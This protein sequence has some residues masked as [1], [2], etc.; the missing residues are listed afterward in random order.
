M[1]S[2][3]PFTPQSGEN[4]KMVRPIPRVVNA[5]P[6]LQPLPQSSGLQVGD[7]YYILFRHKWKILLCSLLGIIL[8]IAFYVRN[9]PPYESRAKLFVRYV[10]AE[11]KPLDPTGEAANMKSPDMRGETIMSAERE[12]LTSFDLA[13]Q[14]AETIGPEKLLTET[15]DKDTDLIRA[16][17]KVSEGLTVDAPRM[18]SV[19]NV[20]FRHT[21]PALVQPVLAEIIS[22]YLKTH[23]DIHRAVGI[24][25]NFLTQ[26]TDQ[27]RTRLAQTE[28]ELRKA[29]NRAGIV[30]LETSKADFATETARIRDEVMRTQAELAERTAILEQLAKQFPD[31]KPA[32]TENQLPPEKLEAYQTALARCELLR[33]REQELLTLFTPENTRVREVRAQL[34]EAEGAKRK[35]EEELPALAR[36]SSPNTTTVAGSQQSQ[37]MYDYATESMRIGALQAKLKVLNGQMEQVRA[38]VANV[39]QMEGAI[40]EL[41]RKKEMEEANYRYYAARLEQS[42]IN[43][44]LGT[45]KV[46][47]ISEIQK[48]TPPSPDWK[49]I[50]KIMGALAGGGIAL[51]LAW[52]FLIEFF[53]DHSVRRPI[54]VERMLGLPLFLS[55]PVMGKKKKPRQPKTPAAGLP[56]GSETP[57]DP[58]SAVTALV[59]SDAEQSRMAVTAQLLYFHETLR[60]RLISYFESVNLTHKP[61][62]VAVTGLDNGSGVTTTAAGLASC[63]SETGEGNV[64]LVDMTA[65]QGSAQQ[66]YR[67]QKVCGLEEILSARASA[68][69]EDNLFV[70]VEEPGRDRLSRILP[71]RFNKLVPQLKASNFD[72]IIFDMPPV[73]QISI[74]PRLAGFMDMVLLVIE[75]E[76]TNRDLVERATA[77]LAQSKAH[78][79]AVLNKTKHYVP[80]RLHQDSLSNF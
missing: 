68:Q 46:S 45:G 21:N 77:L 32:E 30:S 62:L 19:I 33:K 34:A 25:G 28:D 47:N 55:I 41:L 7:I 79:G 56:S 8:A 5:N 15:T 24:I 48:P 12:I 60:D 13:K 39:D 42:R 14:V 74:T 71:Q 17:V 40:L 44:A 16:A 64:L 67:G 49:K 72:Y 1:D 31:N 10:V 51:G 23:V 2:K 52:A 80:K 38:Q 6:G 3:S 18:S 69:V 9:P 66:F 73:S 54:D 27:L 76:K 20:S 70:V 35:L 59:K 22:R 50:I 63:L 37:G 61:K 4:P 65:G 43:E 26:E 78:V 58:A 57:A 75:S 11:N 53:L 29:R 36:I